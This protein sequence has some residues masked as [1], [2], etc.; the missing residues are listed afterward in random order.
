MG[1]VVVGFGRQK[2]MLGCAEDATCLAEIGGALGVDYV[3]TG[4]LGRLGNLTRVDLKLVDARKARVVARAGESVTGEEERLV[5]TV[6]GA[7]RELLRA[8]SP[9][10]GA[11]PQAPA[12][13]DGRWAVRLECPTFKQVKGY[14]LNFE[15]AVAKGSFLAIHGTPGEPGSLRIE[16]PVRPD[17]TAVLVAKGLT[18]PAEYSGASSGPG[19]P[20]R[21]RVKAAFSDREGTGTRVEQRPCTFAFARR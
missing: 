17:G 15:G 9:A 11:G 18:G 16:G 6:Q 19:T 14:V 4:S 2:K 21:Y 13:F 7:V 8:A 12:R 3:L 20:Y 1:N 5:S 10:T